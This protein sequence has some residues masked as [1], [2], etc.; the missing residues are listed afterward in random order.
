MGF[1]DAE[2]AYA[3]QLPMREKVIL[4]AVALRTDDVSHE[5]FVGH[6]TIA[7]MTGASVDT[8]R[9]S[10][11]VL[12][13]LGVI[14]RTR[15]HGMGGYRTS[16]LTTLNT[17]TYPAAG[18]QGSQPS[19]PATYEADSVDLTSSQP[20]PTR[21]TAGAEEIIQG[22]HPEDHPAAHPHETNAIHGLETMRRELTLPLALDELLTHAYRVGSGDPWV[23]YMA[24]RRECEA[25]LSAARNPAAVL[26]K[27][28]T[29][30]A[31]L[32]DPALPEDDAPIG[33]C[34]H[35]MLT[36]RHCVL[37]DLTEVSI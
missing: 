26:R 12:E 28:L 3:L 4:A 8:V 20:P 15:R 25:P 6:Q 19:R 30:I 17:E 5:T 24:L 35:R 2:W 16:D 18:L 7:T 13:R 34:G 31:P 36:E 11:G 14:R 9:R 37:G 29:G 1:K 23:G 27:R 32:V 22:Y 33:E 10:L 21:L